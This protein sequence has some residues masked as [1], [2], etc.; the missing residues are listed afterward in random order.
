MLR[1]T[2]VTTVAVRITVIYSC[3]VFVI[4]WQNKIITRIFHLRV[5][6]VPILFALTIWK[7]WFIWGLF[8][9]SRLFVNVLNYL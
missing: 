7:L 3:L 9:V 5:I 2:A 4:C 8:Y 1:R 6:T